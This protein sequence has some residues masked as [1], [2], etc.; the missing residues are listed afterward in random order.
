MLLRKINAV[1]SLI[2]TLLLLNHAVYIALYIF[3]N[4]RILNPLH[5]AVWGL[6]GVMAL[7][8]FISIDLAI[9]AHMEAGKQKGKSYPKKNISTVL[10]RISGMLLIPL[11]AL[12]IA[13]A[14]GAMTPPKL[15]HSILP[16]LF[17]FVALAH[18]ALSASKALVTLGIGSARFVRVA[19]IVIKVFCALTLIADVV[20]F[21]VLYGF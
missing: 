20:G 11:V 2:S 16:P 1:L 5:S 3:S 14:T 12:H 8:A 7:H 13:G 4:G 10:Q 15:V 19:D 6:V 9:S 21:Y 17:F 18:T